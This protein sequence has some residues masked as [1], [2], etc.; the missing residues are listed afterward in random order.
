M[1][2][3]TQGT[4]LGPIPDRSLPPARNSRTRPRPRR[5]F[6]RNGDPRA[7]SIF[8]ARRARRDGTARTTGGR[9]LPAC[10][11]PV[12]VLFE[13]SHL[14]GG[15]SSRAVDSS[16]SFR[17]PGSGRLLK[18][19][20]RVGQVRAPAASRPRR[21]SSGRRPGPGARRSRTG[22]R[23]KEPVEAAE[24]CRLARHLGPEPRPGGF[25][26]PLDLR[27]EIFTSRISYAA[28]YRLRIPDTS[29]GA[30]PSASR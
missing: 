4:R 23:R 8:G 5:K 9:R 26:R 2:V 25:R 7:G 15:R 21:P 12:A 14:E 27:P 11:R 10:S 1:K 24:L 13:D 22:R 19:R 6:S 30:W 28:K 18:H 3:V 20:P 17:V 29:A 16:R